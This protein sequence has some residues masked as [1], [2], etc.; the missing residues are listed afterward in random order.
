[1]LFINPLN[2]KYQRHCLCVG[3]IIRL[4]AR[5]SRLQTPATGKAMNTGVNLHVNIKK[6]K[7]RKKEG[8]KKRFTVSLTTK[9]QGIAMPRQFVSNLA[10]YFIET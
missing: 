1:M 8:V 2:G 9:R 5:H 4:E 10:G 3:R 6:K 7:T